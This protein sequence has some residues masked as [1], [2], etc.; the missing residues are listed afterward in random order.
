[1]VRAEARVDE[2]LPLVVTTLNAQ[3]TERLIDLAQGN[4]RTNVLNAPK[5]TIFNGT[6]AICTA[7]TQRPF[8][9]GVFQRSAGANEPKIVMLEEG[10]GIKV[11]AVVGSDRKKVHLES[12]IG[13]RSIGDVETA[14]TSYRGSHVSIQV[15]S[16]KRRSIDV[17]ADVAAGETL[18]VG[19]IPTGKE[20]RY[21]YYLL[22]A[23]RIVE[24]VSAVNQVK[25]SR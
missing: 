23:K 16:M 6:E 20:Q 7:C 24:T 19:C 12:S 22:S 1:V 5:I 15:P 10:T 18:L 17:A 2:Y 21:S 13:M 25:E 9:V 3:Q 4:R 14:S 8:V 11:R